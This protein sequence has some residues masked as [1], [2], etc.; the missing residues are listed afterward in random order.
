MTHTHEYHRMIAA[1]D[2]TE[3][4]LMELERRLREAASEAI[5]SP[6]A[7][8]GDSAWRKSD[9]AAWQAALAE[10]RYRNRNDIGAL[11]AKLERQQRAIRAWLSRPTNHST[12]GS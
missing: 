7:H 8:R 6:A 3:K 4:R 9:E 5:S 1:R 12:A 2:T 10:L 11:K